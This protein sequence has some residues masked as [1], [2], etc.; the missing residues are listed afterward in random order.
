[1]SN[2]KVGQNV[3]HT[4]HGVGKIISIE[5]IEF[6]PDK[7]DTFYVVEIVDNGAPKKVFCPIENNKL[8]SIIDAS[9]AKDV[10]Q[11]FA[12]PS[13][14]VVDSSTWNRRYI[15]YMGMINTDN[16]LDTATVVKELRILG[17]DKDLSFGEMKLLNCASDLLT[18][19]LALALNKSERETDIIIEKAL[20]EGITGEEK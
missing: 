9:V 11:Y 19:E 5:T 14:R 4:S 16:I 2:F 3:V 10:L 8:R 13:S 17:Q 15:K 7:K 12:N 6:A 18:K 1:M 20:F